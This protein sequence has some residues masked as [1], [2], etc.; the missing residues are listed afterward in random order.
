MHLR[1]KRLTLLGVGVLLGTAAA[2]GWAS[3]LPSGTDL[4]EGSANVAIVLPVG[5]ASFQGE[6]NT[7]PA[8]GLPHRVANVTA[9]DEDTNYQLRVEAG[10]LAV[11][12]QGEFVGSCGSLS[13]NR[14]SVVDFNLPHTFANNFGPP[15]KV[16]E[17]HLTIPPDANN[18]CTVRKAV[19]QVTF[20]AIGPDQGP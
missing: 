18:N 17:L 4:T 3:G 7:I 2:V 9:T 8:N 19:V 5:H 6:V 1:F 14:Y 15:I 11:V 20:T 10:G 16:G 12:S 13:P